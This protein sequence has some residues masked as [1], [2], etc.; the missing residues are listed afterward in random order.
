[1]GRMDLPHFWGVNRQARD[2]DRKPFAWY[3]TFN[4][5]VLHEALNTWW[6][7]P[8]TVNLI[9]S[10]LSRFPSSSSWE[11]IFSKSSEVISPQELQCCRRLVQLCRDC[12]LVVYKFVSESRGSLSGLSPEWDDTRWEGH[13]AIGGSFTLWRFLKHSCRHRQFIE[14]KS[15]GHR[16]CDAASTA[17][18]SLDHLHS[19]RCLNFQVLLVYNKSDDSSICD[20]LL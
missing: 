15:E 20:K 13:V 5:Q 10:L 12:L 8:V 17:W 6:C 16:L 2:I 7:F 18:P 3:G 9:V 14:S 19:L 1:M 11:N 4:I